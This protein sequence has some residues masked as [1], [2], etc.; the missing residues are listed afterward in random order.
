MKSLSGG[1]SFTIAG[2]NFWEGFRQGIITSG[3]NHFEYLGAVTIKLAE[4]R[5][6][7]KERSIEKCGKSYPDLPVKEGTLIDLA[8][9]FPELY[10]ETVQDFSIAAVTNINHLRKN[11]LDYLIM[12][13]F[14][15]MGQT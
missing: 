13:R 10:K 4:L 3:L 12:D 5:N 7:I 8:E 11:I 1:I 6:Q 14:G 15:K 2:G 9:I